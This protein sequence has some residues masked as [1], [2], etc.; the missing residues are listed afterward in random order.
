MLSLLSRST[1]ALSLTTRL[2]FS[3]SVGA[4]QARFATAAK[5]LYGSP[6]NPVDEDFEIN[7][8]EGKK[9]RENIHAAFASRA[10]AAIKY[11]YFAQRAELECELDSAS[12]F[13]GLMEAS[14][15]QAMGYLEL[16]EEYGDADFGSTIDNLEISSQ[17]E[18]DAADQLYPKYAE[19]ASDE[20]LDQVDQ[21]FQ[22][23]ADA[24]SRAADR[25]DF[26]S[27][28]MEAEAEEY[29]GTDEDEEQAESA[30]EKGA[31][32]K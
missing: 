20:Q 10:M 9:T 7:L 17:S 16:M 12:A 24:S 2:Q 32:A 4:K 18:R 28:L 31:P 5:G 23:M 6:E 30:S 1:R 14:K 27:S 22:E 8:L 13:K 3:R 26:T 29:D 15:Q 11:E 19:A 21:W 25:L